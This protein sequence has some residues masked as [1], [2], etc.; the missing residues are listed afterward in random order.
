MVSH[1]LAHHAAALHRDFGGRDRQLVGLARV[2]GVLLDGARSVLPSTPPSAPASWPAA[3]CATTGRGCPTAIWL[4]AVAIV[5]VP[6]RTSPTTFERLA[7]MFLSASISW[8]VSSRLSTSMRCSGR[9]P[10]RFRRPSGHGPAGER[11]RRTAAMRAAR[12]P[13]AR[14]GKHHHEPAGP[15]LVRDAL[16]NEVDLLALVRGELVDA[17]S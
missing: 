16:R 4:D 10:P 2:V 9:R 5:S 12:L 8:P 15:V 11:C 1:H 3:R 13:P 17:P 6:W 7:F 14:C